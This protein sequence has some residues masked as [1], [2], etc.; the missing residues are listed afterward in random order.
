VF[1]G[2]LVARIRG[3]YS[4]GAVAESHQIGPNEE[5]IESCSDATRPGRVETRLPSNSPDW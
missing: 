2:L 4:S 5:P 1:S 3:G